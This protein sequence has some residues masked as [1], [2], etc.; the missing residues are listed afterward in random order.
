MD[1]K[2]WYLQQIDLFKGIPDAD[3]MEIAEKIVEK[4]CHKKEVNYTPFEENKYICL[5]K[6]GEVTLYH[7]HQGRKL[8]ID[9]LKPGAV[10]G[11]FSFDEN[12]SEHFAEVTEDAYMCFFEMKDFLK[13]LQARPELMLR[14]MK[15][16]S[17]RIRE[18]ENK[19]K[20]G[21]YDAKQKIIHHL[22]ILEEKNRKSLLNR[23]RPSRSKLTHNKLAQQIGLSRETVTRAITDLK[24]EGKIIDK[25]NGTLALP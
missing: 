11:N 20:G 10:F 24:K 5:L 6:K 21:L 23:L 17:G 4:K 7:S 16:M 22:A 8:I 18:Y 14:F 15:I 12:K 25:E 19:M 9:I 2:I 3:I 13:I 1:E